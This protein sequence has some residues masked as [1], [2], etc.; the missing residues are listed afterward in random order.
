MPVDSGRREF[1]KTGAV[2]LISVLWDLSAASARE[3]RMT[4]TKK[5]LTAVSGLTYDDVRAVSPAL[6][7]YTKRAL[8][9]GL[10]KRQIQKSCRAPRD[11]V[12]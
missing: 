10:W 6:E 4:D 1:I 12:H 9:D 11:T 8:L 2:V 7:H 5:P 3:N